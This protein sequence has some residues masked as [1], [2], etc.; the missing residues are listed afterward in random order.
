MNGLTI[1]KPYI[2][3]DIVPSQYVLPMA[4][5]SD[6]QQLPLRSLQVPE[7]VVEADIPMKP[8]FFSPVAHQNMTSLFQFSKRRRSPH[9]SRTCEEAMEL[10]KQV[11]RQDIRSQHRG[12]G[13]I[14]L[15]NTVAYM[16]QSNEVPA[17]T[18]AQDSY[19]CTLDGMQLTF[20]HLEDGIW[21]ESVQEANR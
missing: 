14:S 5:T 4:T 11:L 7:W 17:E 21:I 19:S 3:Y 1:V 9:I 15:T 18:E 6:G 10:I 20:Q 13:N 8:V 12:R 16:Q 2:P